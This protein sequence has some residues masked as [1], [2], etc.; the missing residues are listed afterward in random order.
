MME[1]R[2]VRKIVA[3]LTACVLMLS[4]ATQ[5]VLACMGITLKA[6]DGSVVFGR[7]LEW[8][9]FD[10]KSRLVVIPRGKICDAHS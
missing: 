3:T 10:L 5:S 8:G 1:H 7:T 2:I 4:S 6:S 9:S